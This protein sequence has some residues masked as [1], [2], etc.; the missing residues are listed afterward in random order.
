MTNLATLIGVKNLETLLSKKENTFLVLTTFSQFTVKQN[1]NDT[2]MS[3]VVGIGSF[4][5]C[6]RLANY[7]NLQKLAEL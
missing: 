4:N 6:N 7:L 2:D 3:K 1:K 5:D